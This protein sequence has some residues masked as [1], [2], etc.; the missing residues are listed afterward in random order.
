MAGKLPLEFHPEAVAELERAMV[1]YNQQRLGLGDSFFQEI[2][3][4]VIRIRDAPNTWPVYERG[5]RRFL[6]HRF[7]FAVDL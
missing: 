6:V 7:P 4:A 1:W 5:T 3:T 2:T